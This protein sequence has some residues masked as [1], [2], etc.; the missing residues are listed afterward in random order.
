MKNRGSSEIR[1]ATLVKSGKPILATKWMDNR[2]VHFLSSF[3]GYE[4]STT[5]RRF[6][7]KAHV[8]KTVECPASVKEYNKFMGGVDAF[9]SFI[10]LYRIKLQCNRRY[11]L[12][13]FFH[14]LDMAVVNAW[15]EYRRDCADSELPKKDWLKLWHF[16]QVIASDLTKNGSILKRRRYSAV[17]TE[18]LLK[19]KRGNTENIPTNTVRR[20]GM[21]HLPKSV[22]NRA[23][24]KN[25]NCKSQVKTICI[26]CKIHLSVCQKSNDFLVN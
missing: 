9:D 15:L 5:V 22:A 3:V 6:D 13:I 14:F 1:S 7:R 4:P 8:Y 12:K 23:K 10:S 21:D 16:K 26:K 11:Y 19:R 25:P 17:E 20:D 24:C 2:P 18:Y